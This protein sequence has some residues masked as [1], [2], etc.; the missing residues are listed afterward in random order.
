MS[1]LSTIG[2]DVKGLLSWLGSPKGQAVVNAGEALV[3]DAFPAATGAINLANTWLVEI[4]KAEALGEAAGSTAAGT[5]T[6]KAA[7]VI[8]SVTPS[9]LTFAKAQGL[10]TPTAANLQ[11]ANDALVTFLEALGAESAKAA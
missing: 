3:E 11:S 7:A 1:I 10:G 8:A 5:D 4:F 9:V 2:K 6:Q